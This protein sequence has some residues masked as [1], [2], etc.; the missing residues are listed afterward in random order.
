[1]SDVLWSFL[2]GNELLPVKKTTW[3]IDGQIVPVPDDAV[4]VEDKGISFAQFISKYEINLDLYA[5]VFL[6]YL[7][8]PDL[9]YVLAYKGPPAPPKATPKP[10]EIPQWYPK[11]F[12]EKGYRLKD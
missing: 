6:R 2:I 9:G 3:E 5:P 7:N 8:H 10:W 12:T 1:M 4:L 11:D